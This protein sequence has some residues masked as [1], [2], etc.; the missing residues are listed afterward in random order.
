MKSTEDQPLLHT[1][2]LQFPGPLGDA[3]GTEKETHVFR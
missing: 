1:P 3:R 2:V